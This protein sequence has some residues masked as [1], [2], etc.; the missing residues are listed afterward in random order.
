MDIRVNKKSEFSA[1]SVVKKSAHSVVKKSAHSDVFCHNLC[2]FAE[3][4]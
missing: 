2:K 1:Y 3:T 4:K